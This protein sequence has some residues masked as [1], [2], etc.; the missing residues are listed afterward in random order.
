MNVSD[1]PGSELVKKADIVFKV[2][3]EVINA[4]F[5]HCG[6]LYSHAECIS[7]VFFKVNTACIE[8]IRVNHSAAKKLKPARALTYIAAFSSADIAADIHLCRRLSEGE[9]RRSQSYVYIVS[10]QFAVQNRKGSA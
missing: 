8:N 5:K 3:P 7:R 4:I 6:A 2:K 10:E 9:K 1:Y